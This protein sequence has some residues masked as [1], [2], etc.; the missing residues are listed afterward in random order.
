[1]FVKP[2]LLIIKTLWEAQLYVKF[3]DETLPYFNL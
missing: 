3:V 1:M 2:D